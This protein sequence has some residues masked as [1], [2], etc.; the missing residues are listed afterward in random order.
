MRNPLIAATALLFVTS[1]FGADGITA[2]RDSN[3]RVVFV[4]AE[5]PTA[6]QTSGSACAAPSA[7]GGYVYWSVTQRRWKRVPTP[8]ATQVR[9]ACSAA[10]E[11]EAKLAT[12]ATP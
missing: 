8:S 4:N 12:S 11:V 6:T 9:N 1:A 10:R 5:R 7:A 3:G 2:V